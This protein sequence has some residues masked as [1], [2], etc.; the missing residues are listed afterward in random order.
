MYN[1]SVDE[2]RFKK[3]APEKYEKWRLE[4]LINYGLNGE[5]LSR[6]ALKKYWNVL[7]IDPAR[8]K[9]L[10]FLLHGKANSN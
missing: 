1:W 4:Q 8:R 7:Q 9:F 3:D 10:D 2:E 5:K 6:K